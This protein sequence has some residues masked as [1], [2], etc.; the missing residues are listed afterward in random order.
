VN[1]LNEFIEKNRN[2][3]TSEKLDRIVTEYNQRI[4]RLKMDRTAAWIAG[5]I[6]TIFIINVTKYFLF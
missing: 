4:K 3:M 6:I 5:P 1:D 2:S